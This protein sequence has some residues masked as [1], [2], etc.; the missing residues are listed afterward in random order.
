MK[1]KKIFG[2]FIF[3]LIPILWAEIKNSDN[4]MNGEWNFVPVKEWEI[5]GSGMEV[6]GE[7][8][9]IRISDEGMVYV[10]DPEYGAN[11][12]FGKTGAFLKTFGKRGQGPGEVRQQRDLFVVN[13]QVF[14]VDT[15]MI[16]IFSKDGEY[17][18][19]KRN[20]SHR[21]RPIV[22]LSHEEF[23]ACPFGIFEA[24]NS[25]GKVSIVNLENRTERVITEFRIFEGGRARSGDL[26]G[27]F[28]MIGLTP[29]MT[30]GYGN[31]RIYY[32]KSDSYVIHIADMDGRVLDSFSLNRKKQRISD[33]VKRRSFEEFGRISRNT[34]EQFI[35]TTPNDCTFFCRIE[36]HDGLIYVFVPE[37]PRRNKQKIDIFS[38]EGRYLYSGLIE[39]EEELSLMHSQ[40]DNPVIKDGYLYAALRDDSHRI[41]IVKYRIKLPTQKESME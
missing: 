9:R 39:L 5:Y 37:I 40:L 26:V 1:V 14:V 8:D 6:W 11:Y 22:F 16:H 24:P 7:P 28:I 3:F 33:E 23:I 15:G 4:P 12:I 18:E 10:S 36:I 30:V 31:Q 38:P 17:I 27:S 19:S 21:F 25:L 29:L 35:E 41:K 34:R 20:Q 2:W 13:S 32:G